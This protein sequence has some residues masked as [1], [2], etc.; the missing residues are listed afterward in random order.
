MT[1]TTNRIMTKRLIVGTQKTVAASSEVLGSQRRAGVRHTLEVCNRSENLV[2]FGGEDVTVE[3]GMPI[4][5]D[6]HRTFYV[7]D[8]HAVF[9]IAEKE[10]EVVIAEFCV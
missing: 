9:L 1:N 8:P 4:L 10:S 6:E 5:P 2:F 3:S 7:S